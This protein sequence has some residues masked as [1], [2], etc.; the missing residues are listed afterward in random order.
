M[1]KKNLLYFLTLKMTVNKYSADISI[2]CPWKYSAEGIIEYW[3]GEWALE[4][5][6][7]SSHPTSYEFCD[8]EQVN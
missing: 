8:L 4:L 5:G 3:L 7:W 1:Q 6:D 2:L